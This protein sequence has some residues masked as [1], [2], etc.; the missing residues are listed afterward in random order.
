MSQPLL[1]SLAAV[2][3]AVTALVHLL[4]GGAHI[5][6]PLLR[7]DGLHPAVRDTHYFCWHLVTIALGGVA[8]AY[9]LAAGGRASLELAVAATVF[10][11][12]AAILNVVLGVRGGHWP[13]RMPQWAFFLV[14]T[15][16]GTYGLL[17]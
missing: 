7:G 6:R 14:T 12:A 17:L 8:L 11:G 10:S 15:V 16:L 3:A 13:W 1:L 9:A 4:A 5:A 2:S